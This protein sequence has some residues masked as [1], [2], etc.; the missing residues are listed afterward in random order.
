MKEL[1]PGDLVIIHAYKDIP[2]DCLLIQGELTLDEGM[3]TGEV[4][5]RVFI[6]FQSVPV[7][8]REID[9]DHEKFNFY[10]SNRHIIFQ[11]TKILRKIPKLYSNTTFDSEDVVALVLRTSFST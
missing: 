10:T 11:G 8:K 5:Y 3:L 6:N 2:A 4:N 9:N 1:V 7:N